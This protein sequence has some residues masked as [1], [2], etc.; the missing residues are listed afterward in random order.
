M[1][2]GILWMV[3][4]G[5]NFVA[6]AAVVKYVG[7]DVPPPQA[8]FLRYLFGL[9][10]LLPFLG[11]LHLARIPRREHV[12]QF[13]RGLIHS[14]GVLCWFYA[15]TQISIAEV[16]SLGYL[17]PVIV[18]VGAGLFLG[19]RLNLVRILSVGGALLGA[20]IVL[21]PGIREIDQGHL[22][23]LGCA[24]F[25]AVSFLMAKRLA[26]RFNSAVI[27]T[28]LSLVSTLC[29][30]PF[31]VAVWVPLTVS[32]FAWLFLVAFLATAG[33]FAMTQ[34]FRNAPVSV[35]QPVNYLQLIWATLLGVLAFGESVDVFVILGGTIVVGSVTAVSW[36]SAMR[37]L[38]RT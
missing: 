14:V 38:R 25:L 35:T 11:H 28:M 8:A 32:Q 6:V 21:R 37:S 29:L 13:V 3:V 31:A 15:M 24:T 18:T 9:V 33:H 20:L 4:S 7:S 30:F 22:A 17:T 10:F 5:L 23:M 1:I 12:L 26:S 16:T 34:S 19:E 27:V 36:Q 2:A